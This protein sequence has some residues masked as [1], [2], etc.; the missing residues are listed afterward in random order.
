MLQDLVEQHHKKDTS[1]AL[2]ACLAFVLEHANIIVSMFEF[3]ILLGAYAHYLQSF[4]QMAEQ[5]Y[6]MRQL[7][8]DQ[9]VA[10]PKPYSLK[11]I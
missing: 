6:L 1:D 3:N 2:D 5:H 8:M 10:K 9:A 7:P 4:K 11:R